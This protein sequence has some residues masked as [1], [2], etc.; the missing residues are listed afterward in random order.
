MVLSILVPQ[1][2]PASIGLPVKTFGILP[3][4]K[5]SDFYIRKY[6]YYVI[7]SSVFHLFYCVSEIYHFLSYV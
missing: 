3:R 1:T 6:S 2:T 7:Y 4:M 5:Y